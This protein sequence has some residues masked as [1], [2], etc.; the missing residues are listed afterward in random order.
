MG[1][2]NWLLAT[3][4][5]CAAGIVAIIGGFLVSRLVALSSEREG[6]KRQLREAES[7]NGQARVAYDAAHQARREQSESSFRG[8]VIDDLSKRVAELGDVD[9][10]SL[11][12]DN[13]PRGSNVAEMKEYASRLIDEAVR[14]RELISRY[15]NAADRKG[16]IYLEDLRERGLSIPNSQEDL[17]DHVSY[18]V[19]KRLPER[20]R[21]G[22]A[23]DMPAF[24]MPPLQV[25]GSHEVEMRRFDETIAKEYE[26]QAA[27]DASAGDVVR[28]KD[29]L[30]KLA[31]P[32][33]IVQAVWVLISLAVFG[34]L[35][36]IVVMAF[37]PAVVPPLGKIILISLFVL[38][39]AI[40]LVYVVWYFRKLKKISD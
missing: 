2:P 24:V 27:L 36:P 38:S 40:L 20:R 6:V 15:I 39:L 32:V 33:G 11:V 3:L 34:I 5:Q 7:R 31:A 21:S 14:V 29:E 37:D 9:V 30:R 28:H 4:S 25:A 8:F 17:Y 22:M 35:P 18:E 19:L 16:E 13:I 1:D 12:D 23:L 26:T 10:D